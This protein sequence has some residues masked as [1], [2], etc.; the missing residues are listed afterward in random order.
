MENYKGK[1]EE[2][3]RFL[4]WA[5]T[6]QAVWESICSEDSFEPIQCLEII[7]E[8]VRNE[9]YLLIP[10]LLQRNKVNF[11]MDKVLYNLIFNKLADVWEDKDLA[12]MIAELETA[13]KQE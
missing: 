7:K 10:V 6:H 13:L 3:I 9:F 8:L 12:V 1:K 5:G 11:A 4:R 2:I